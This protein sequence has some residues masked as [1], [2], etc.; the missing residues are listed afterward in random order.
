MK[1]SYSILVVIFFCSC[2]FYQACTSTSVDNSS[3]AENIS[4]NTIQD[5]VENNSS[6][7]IDSFA[8]FMN[9]FDTLNIPFIIDSN[10]GLNEPNKHLFEREFNRHQFLMY[11]NGIEDVIT[12]SESTK[13]RYGA[14]TKYKD[15]DILIYWVSKYYEIPD[16]LSDYVDS[17]QTSDPTFEFGWG[18]AFDTMVM[19]MVVFNKEGKMI[20]KNVIGGYIT[21]NQIVYGTLTQ[22]MQIEMTTRLALNYSEIVNGHQTIETSIIRQYFFI[23]DSGKIE[24]KKNKRDERTFLERF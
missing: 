12:P 17:L 23:N 24:E 19:E 22:E 4:E 1:I 21:E 15:Y 5:F 16:S 20:S 9:D 11:L 6:G 13:F 18:D 8:I 14:K 7:V 10:L 2:C 3:M